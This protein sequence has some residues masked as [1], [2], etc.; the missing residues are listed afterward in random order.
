MHG[1]VSWKSIARIIQEVNVVGGLIIPIWGTIE[2][3]LS[4][5]WFRFVCRHVK[6]TRIET[7][8]DNQRIVGLSIPN[9]AVET[10]LQ[11]IITKTFLM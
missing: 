7:T 3:A 2:K 11:G 10:V 6:V 4:K 8:T 9:A 1:S 5:Q